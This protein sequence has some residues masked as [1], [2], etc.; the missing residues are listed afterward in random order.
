MVYK[1]TPKSLLASSSSYSPPVKKP[2]LEYVPKSKSNFTSIATYVPSTSTSIKSNSDHESEAQKSGW[3]YFTEVIESE[4][5]SNVDKTPTYVPTKIERSTSVDAV[6]QTQDGNENKSLA[7][8]IIEIK[9]S[10]SKQE[11]SSDKTTSRHDRHKS[12]SKSTSRSSHSSK[13]KHESSSKTSSERSRS[14]KSAHKSTQEKTKSHSSRSV[15]KNGSEEQK[16][17][18]PS[19]SKRHS[20][21]KTS[22][23]STKSDDRKDD[24]QILPTKIKSSETT[25]KENNAIVHINSDNDISP[26]SIFDTDS[27]EDDVMAQCRMIFEEFKEVSDNGKLNTAVVVS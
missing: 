19:S 4:T 12:S 27:E 14:S 23:T 1:P 6:P 15:H 18:K 3:D 2:K 21:I 10:K 7:D 9:K 5:S 13:N 8:D 17:V 25:K 16:S 24:E 11:K 22:A 26:S 20:K